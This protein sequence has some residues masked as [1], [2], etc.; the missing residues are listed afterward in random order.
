MR[1]EST[2][3]REEIKE[4]LKIYRIAVMH[5]KIILERVKITLYVLK[6]HSHVLKSHSGVLYFSKF[7]FFV[8]FSYGIFILAIR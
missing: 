1:V 6:S 5:L 2:R 3:L 7:L 4:I 8:D